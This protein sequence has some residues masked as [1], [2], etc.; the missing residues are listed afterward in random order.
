MAVPL[1]RLFV[2]M[3]NEV[4]SGFTNVNVP[5]VAWFVTPL[6]RLNC[7]VQPAPVTTCGKYTSA[8]PACDISLLGGVVVIRNSLRS[9]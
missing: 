4:P 1:I 5:L 3:W 2:P 8:V 6:K 7:V 9:L